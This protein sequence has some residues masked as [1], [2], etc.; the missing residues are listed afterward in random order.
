MFELERERDIR[1]PKINLVIVLKTT[2]V[3][4][5]HENNEKFTKPNCYKNTK[6]TKTKQKLKS[7]MYWLNSLFYITTF[8]E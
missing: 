6:Q 7:Q 2:R 5:L 4:N 1:T 8:E 3:E